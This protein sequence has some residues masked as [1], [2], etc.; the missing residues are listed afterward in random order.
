[1]NWF[2]RE[3]VD[4][5]LRRDCSGLVARG[6]D[7]RL[8]RRLG[9]RLLSA[10]V[11]S[12]VCRRARPAPAGVRAAGVPA[13]S[14]S[15]RRDCCVSEVSVPCVV[16][17]AA[18]PSH[19]SQLAAGNRYLNALQTFCLIKCLLSWQIQA[20][21]GLCFEVTR[22]ILLRFQRFRGPSQVRCLSF[23]VPRMAA[24]STTNPT[25]ST[26]APPQPVDFERQNT[27]LFT[28]RIRA[29]ETVKKLT[30]E[31]EAMSATDPARSET[32]RGLRR[33]ESAAE[34]AT[35]AIVEANFGLVLSYCRRFTSRSSVADSDDY[36]AAGS[37]GLMEAV[38]TYDPSK[39]KFSSW[40]YKPIQRAVLRSV[41]STEFANMNHGDFE[42]RPS[43]LEAAVSLQGPPGETDVDPPSYEEIARAASATVGQ[44][45][46]VLEAPRLDSLH[47][48][49]GDADGATVGELIPDPSRGVEDTVVS[50]VSVEVLT[51]RCL[52]V[53]DERELQ[54]VVWRH[55]LNGD[56]PKRLN[57]I[58]DLLGISRETARQIERRAIAKL[59][60]PVMLAELSPAP[61]VPL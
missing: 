51:D 56:P 57:K 55:G 21:L 42:K 45:R 48:P 33:A 5:V 20:P 25:C 47:A 8:R 11:P 53:L 49:V 58:A 4:P 15:A 24:V 34:S 35:S 14:V 52:P 26:V 60:H 18:G 6:K 28:K 10:A 27:R 1:M 32:E 19:S 31:L 3:L 13:L 36:K 43:I 59:G 12:A 30:A 54:V 40:A 46:R 39:G 37:L 29:L 50:K 61:S 16:C 44:V 7:L 22:N 23:E 2:V 9:V 38:R 17:A 41:G